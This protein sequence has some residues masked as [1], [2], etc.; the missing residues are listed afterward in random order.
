MLPLG[1]GLATRERA[2][3]ASQF[4]DRKEPFGDKIA[5]S[6]PAQL[7]VFG[8]PVAHSDLVHEVKENIYKSRRTEALGKGVDRGYAFPEQVKDTK[9][10]FGV[11][12]AGS[13]FIR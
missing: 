2:E 12:T 3:L 9:F 6:D 5:P 7:V 11:P 4:Q 8:S 13:W 10:S 1:K